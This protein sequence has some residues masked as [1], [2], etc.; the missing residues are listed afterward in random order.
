MSKLYTMESD[1]VTYMFV[2]VRDGNERVGVFGGGLSVMNSIVFGI[3]LN[4][5]TIKRSPTY[6]IVKKN[7]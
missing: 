4:H 5:L 7:Y 1:A 3:R 6:L 2:P